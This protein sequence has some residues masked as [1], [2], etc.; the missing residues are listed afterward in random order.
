MPHYGKP[1]SG[2]VRHRRLGR[3]SA[4]VAAGVLAVGP[5]GDVRSAQAEDALSPYARWV[6]TGTSPSWSGTATVDVAG[7]PAV[8]AGTNGNSTMVPSGSSIW[9]SAVTPF[10]GVFGSSKERPYLVVGTA[11]G[12]GSSTTTISFVAPTPT[13]VADSGWGFALG[14]VDADMVTVSALNARGEP[15]TVAELGWQGSFNYCSVSPKPTGC[16]GGT[17][18]DEPT[19]NAA[20]STLIGNGSDTG[21]ASGWFRPTVALSSITLLFSPVVGFPSY[22]IWIA[23]AGGLEVSGTVTL[24][25]DGTSA[26]PIA[27]ATVALL[28]SDGAPVTVGGVPVETTSGVDGAWTLVGLLPSDGY[29][30]R[31]TDPDDT[32]TLDVEFDLSDGSLAD[33]DVV[34]ERT[35]DPSPGSTVP[36]STVPG[37]TV[38]GSTDVDGGP[39]PSVGGSVVAPVVSAVSMVVLGFAVAG[40]AR[41]RIR[42]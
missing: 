4:V 39:L 25:I 12:N 36:G 18:T 22:Q 37:S 42:R 7:F 13:Q 5:M 9:L 8:T 31:V 1:L 10:G 16:P 34:F 35:G 41:R 24:E 19:W 21:G 3:I 11:S 28:G 6:A 23:A 30:V 17:S 2:G 38:P 32:G 20:T 15:V 33:I 14:D 26:G 40:S 29:S 27:G